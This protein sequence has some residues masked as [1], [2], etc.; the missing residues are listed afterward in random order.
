MA[1]EVRKPSTTPA[2]RSEE[3]I[4]LCSHRMSYG[5]NERR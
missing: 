3:P 4:L 5:D 2:S 1:A